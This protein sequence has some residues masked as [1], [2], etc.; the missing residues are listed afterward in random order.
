MLYN[1]PQAIF[2]LI[3]IV[4]KSAIRKI[5]C[6]FNTFIKFLD[7]C[8]ISMTE[9]KLPDKSLIPLISGSPIP[10]LLSLVFHSRSAN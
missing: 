3:K 1:T 2:R 8:Q 4:K 10:G 9:I 7:F 5:L 6:S